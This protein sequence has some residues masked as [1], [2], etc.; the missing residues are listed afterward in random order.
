MMGLVMQRFGQR[1]LPVLLLCLICASFPR[2]AFAE[3][4]D[5]S[6]A[7]AA[8]AVIV[9]FRSGT[10]EHSR[11][12][13]RSVLGAVFNK[14]LPLIDAEL[15]SVQEDPHVEAARLA[16]E[17]DVLYA[18]PDYLQ[19]ADR[20]PND[21]R[22]GEQWSLDNTGQT[23][24]APDADID[25]PE[26]WDLGLGNPI[27]LGII[28]T[29][30]DSLHPDLAANLWT[31]PGEI[32]GN[33]LDDDSNGYIDDIHGWDFVQ[34]DN[35]PFDENGHGTHVA[36]IA[37]A[38]G[39]NGIGVAGVH[40]SAQL[41][42]LR[43]LNADGVGSTSS[44]VLALQYAV[45]MGIPITNNSWGGGPFS[46]ALHD[47]ITA[48]SDSGMLFVAAAGNNGKNTDITPHY[49]SSYDLDAIISVAATNH[50]DRLANEL[51]WRSN[52]GYR[53]VDLG[54]PGVEVLSTWP[55]A[56]YKVLSGTSMAAPHVAGAAALL[57]S[58]HPELTNLQVKA[59]LLATTDKLPDLLQ[60]T[61]SGGRLNLKSA[62]ADPDSIAP[63]A[64]FDLHVHDVQGT[65]ARLYFSAP[66]D[67]GTTGTASRYV[68]RYATLPVAT[69]PPGAVV[70]W[71][72]DLTP[73]SPE[74]VEQIEVAGLS[75][76]TTYYFQVLAEDEWFN[77]SGASNEASVTTLGP[78]V[79]ERSDSVLQVPLVAGADTTV[80]C[81]LYNRGAGEMFFQANVEY[82][83]ERVPLAASAPLDTLDVLLVY[84]DNGAVALQEQLKT[85]NDVGRVQTWY[86]GLG[87]GSIPRF[88]D[89]RDYDVVIAWNNK[90]WADPFEIG[91]LLAEC[92][93]SGV[94]V[95]T[96]VDC[97]GS[98]PFASLGRYFELPGYS[99]FVST[100]EALFEVHTLGDF[101]ETHPI[102]K[103]VNELAIAS[104]HNQ[105][106]LAD[107]ARPVAR[108]NDG[109]PLVATLPGS[110]AI[111]V[112]PG[113]GYHWLGDFPTLAHNAVRYAA[114]LDS[115]LDA[116]PSAGE[117]A[118]GDSV[119]LHLNL[120]GR[121]LQAGEYAGFVHLSTSDP[122][123]PE[124]DQQVVLSVAGSA[125]LSGSDTTLEW[126]E[127][128]GYPDTVFL[129]LRNLGT[130][131][132]QAHSFAFDVGHFSTGVDTLQIPPGAT[133][134]L[135]VIFEPF[136]VGEIWCNLDFVS[137]D[138]SR[139]TAHTVLHVQTELPPALNLL[140]ASTSANLISGGTSHDTLRLANDGEGALQFRSILR[141]S[142]SIRRSLAAAA[143]AGSPVDSV[144]ALAWS[145]YADLSPGSEFETFKDALDDFATP[146]SLA[147]TRTDS[148]AEL[149][150]LL[151]DRTL[152][153]V[154]EQENAMPDLKPIATSFAGVLHDF[155]IRGG[156][157]LF[158]SEW[159]PASGL[160]TSTGL[161]DVHPVGRGS[162]IPLLKTDPQH[163]LL[164][165]VSDSLVGS[166]LTTWYQVQSPDAQI[167]VSDTA[168]QYGVVIEN[169]LGAGRTLVFGFDFFAYNDDMARLLN[170]AVLLSR[171]NLAWLDVTP[172]SGRVEAGEHIDLVVNYDADAL[173]GG[174]YGAEIV[175]ETND[176][177][178]RRWSVPVALAVT[179]GAYL[180][181]LSP[182]SF[183]TVFAGTLAERTLAV[184]NSGNRVLHIDSLSAPAAGYQWDQVAFDVPPRSVYDLPIR[185]QSF[186]VGY[187][188]SW[189][190]LYIDD[191]TAA[192][193]SVALTAQVYN[194]PR[195]VMD[196]DTIRTQL[197]EGSVG[198]VQWTLH[199]AGGSPL[200]VA[201]N[202]RY[203]G[204]ATDSGAAFAV[205][206]DLPAPLS[207]AGVAGTSDGR[208]FVY[209]GLA[210]G[211][212]ISTFC[213]MFNPSTSEWQTRAAMP[214]GDY[215]M[216]TAVD[217]QG[218]M[219]SFSGRSTSSLRYDP[220]LDAWES[221][222][223]MPHD[224]VFG[225][226]A[227]LGTDGLIYVTG[228]EGAGPDDALRLVQVYHP[229]SNYW[230]V[231]PPL[232]I[233]R[234]GH[235]TVAT[236]DGR[237]YVIGGR[238]SFFGPPTSTVEMFDPVA[239]AWSLLNDRPLAGTR[240]GFCLG[241][242]QKI[243]TFGG[244]TAYE[245]GL[246]PFSSE[247]WIF[248]P[249]KDAW[250][251]GPHLPRGLA[252][253]GAVTAGDY[254]RILGGNDSTVVATQWGLRNPAWLGWKKSEFSI[255]A[256]DSLAL[257]LP[258]S[259]L[260]LAP[261]THAGHAT[262]TSNDLDLSEVDRP[263]E[264]T[265]SASP[266]LWLVDTVVSFGPELIGQADS[267]AID[268]VNVGSAGLEVSITS[269][270]PSEFPPPNP[271]TVLPQSNGRLWIR[272]T[273]TFAGPVLGQLE[274]HTNDPK[275]PAVTLELSALGAQPGLFSTDTSALILNMPPLAETTLTL[276]LRNDGA[277]PIHW[278]VTGADSP[279]I[280]PGA[281]NQGTR[282]ELTAEAADTSQQRQ[283]AGLVIAVTD[284]RFVPGYTVVLEDLEARG[285]TVGSYARSM[286]AQQLDSIDVLVIDDY[287][288]SL[289]AEDVVELRNWVYRGGRLLV[290]NRR[291]TGIDEANALLSGT[292]LVLYA[293][294]QEERTH[295]HFEGRAV[296][297]GADSIVAPPSFIWCDAGD[298]AEVLVE[299]DNGR[300]VVAASRWG[301]GRMAVASSPLLENEYVY[302]A[303]NRAFLKRL[304]D[305]LAVGTPL[306]IVPAKGTIAPGSTANVQLS[307]VSRPLQAGNYDE[308]VVF[309]SDDPAHDRMKRRVSLAVSGQ[310]QLHVAADTVWFDTAFVGYVTTAHLDVTNF[311]TAPLMISQ[312]GTSSQQFSVVDSESVVSPLQS[313]RMLIRFTPEAQGASDGVMTLHTNDPSAPTRSVVL[314]AYAL[315]PPILASQ[316]APLE[317]TLHA[318]DTASVLLNLTN[319]GESDLA[320]TVRVWPDTSGPPV[321][322][323]LWRAGGA[324]EP[325]D[326]A[327][328][329]KDGH[330]ASAAAY[331][332]Q[333][334]YVTFGITDQGDL[335]EF[336]YP[337]AK[338]QLWVS[339]TT[340]VYRVQGVDYVKGTY[341]DNEWLVGDS[342]K[343]EWM[344]SQFVAVKFFGHTDDG[345]VGVERRF[346]F[347]NERKYVA[348]DTRLVNL[349]TERLDDV[350][351]K[352][353]S[354]WDLDLSPSND[355]WDYDTLR[356]MPYGWDQHYAGIAALERPDL[357]D[358]EGR[359][360][361]IRRFTHVDY[362][363]GPVR[364]ID[365]L[366]ILHFEL[367]GLEPGGSTVIHTILAIGD[368]L[369][370]LQ[371]EIDRGIQPVSWLRADLRSTIIAP[372]ARLDLPLFFNAG[373][374][375]AGQYRARLVL[376]SNDPATPVVEWPVLLRVTGAPAIHADLD[377]LD[378][379]VTYLGY[380]KTRSLRVSNQGT[381]SLRIFDVTGDLAEVN[382]S[383]T[384]ALLPPGRDSLLTITFI[385]RDSGGVTGRI[386]LIHDDTVRAPIE[387][388]VSAQVE[389]PPQLSVA[390]DTLAITLGAGTV[391]NQS[392]SLYNGGRGVLNW[393]F[394][395]HA[396]ITAFPSS[397][398]LPSGMT[399]LITFRVSAVNLTPGHILSAVELVHND[400]ARGPVAIPF[401]LDVFAVRRGDTYTD[402]R[403]DLR[404]IVFLVNSVWKGGPD[405][406]GNSGDL[407][408]DQ[409]VTMSDLT[410]L[411]NLIL[412]DGP[413]PDCPD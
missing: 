28:D 363:E 255:D 212:S 129:S 193:D 152:F 333:G 10:S 409:A 171:Q 260:G 224:R 145:R 66:G 337:G 55:G 153:V 214:S 211:R 334:R 356:Q 78:P 82:P 221:I 220:A 71:I 16:A 277:G 273:P 104:Y 125:S 84:A 110:V 293:Q 58:E 179:D 254:I 352:Q 317:L 37:A 164:K 74:S 26:A 127:F 199:N 304:I 378:F 22:F 279:V 148:P 290:Q 396:H 210:P 81:V 166:N 241:K 33:G 236:P 338:D 286:T 349:T 341:L 399:A 57:W 332:H 360:D 59:R 300:A 54:A 407:D 275:R 36:G 231:A 39:N 406:V 46:Q 376:G 209:G 213:Y 50:A 336:K 374:L 8:P 48:A 207:Q 202:P 43:F 177:A 32:P 226:S 350:V 232:E 253:C 359:L 75:Y 263:I 218:R 161:V 375:F 239:H 91:A 198:T 181:E 97:W 400:P 267:I 103:G 160:A 72:P 252:E 285:A 402:N 111:N 100:G 186:A 342:L 68:V 197:L 308:A 195:L 34:W 114:G 134:L 119:A 180:D 306:V 311:G 99:P 123:S 192:G 5:R 144:R 219:Y 238:T 163:P 382:P 237:L 51:L 172:D 17:P 398:T 223:S 256:G 227:T 73:Q 302:R 185:F 244:K 413:A 315:R 404:D 89:V 292:G 271:I 41:V 137:N 372:G 294:G 70:E 274:L 393:S 67:D 80:S 96:F 362:P 289:F 330:R 215:G 371:R 15:W 90:P 327:R 383:W 233:Q 149:E 216:A 124:V 162:Q 412:K 121:R 203:A 14:S 3:S 309:H 385:P 30:I 321:R 167:V 102:M 403:L 107:G 27:L 190:R 157:V 262:L 18:E 60:T 319:Q 246:G 106:Q 301:Q 348:M 264:V 53:S 168:G 405:P 296:A 105:V 35:Q 138:P 176:P 345:R 117:V 357:I 278:R 6:T 113:D 101:V 217:R 380:P 310:A 20:I 136:A 392:F 268:L 42:P 355:N 19:R 170:N 320:M 344:D 390:D 38:I 295:I 281:A 44:A 299:D 165:D 183:G 52:F 266:G 64:V 282:H 151:F 178:T 365:G 174:A 141:G 379:G 249:L 408:C 191:S 140:D 200:H 305:W 93:D 248:D 384:K 155:V 377:S 370:D 130:A 205:L 142:G 156:T 245:D 257:E 358:I 108:W 235:A 391:A 175:L 94:A 368:S 133:G 288:G 201:L 389:W 194:A 139:L 76:G 208:V 158:L 182:V 86:A 116:F 354:D 65:R 353:H 47:A 307:T 291:T 331:S 395:P 335:N 79:L 230:T 187:Y 276:S 98:G 329:R 4:D 228:G 188:D 280:D 69:A 23:Q 272:C 87:T 251:E 265:V 339:G 83:H 313:L 143:S 316:S 298:S 322:T 122:M 88:R 411:I 381:D 184:H 243:Y 303:D 366:P 258:L 222:A 25:A 343:S 2:S 206:S 314:K 283:L 325:A 95:V 297:W 386:V 361:Y 9:R 410:M 31:N 247:V 62:L 196:T 85:F 29:G 328:G 261:G 128:M 61:V 284:A 240:F 346:S 369:S 225:A 12:T 40:W 318:G 401:A 287:V 7:P 13:A 126:V 24:G 135:P 229:D 326:G 109:T 250:S 56:D 373:D 63:D 21:P 189:L 146:V 397:G 347:E 132:L 394:S 147:V 312:I 387:L 120:D 150:E 11:Q 351:Y 77:Q 269:S 131:P 1:G 242:D 159:G 118:P 340:I 323:M 367:G 49:P 388:P 45:R 270:A 259:A 234:Y 364:L 204:V 169:R 112:W 324:A 154:L 173:D 115:W 92:V